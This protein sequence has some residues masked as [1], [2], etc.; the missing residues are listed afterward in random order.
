MV[1]EIKSP[2]NVY[3]VNSEKIF[4][5]DMQSTSNGNDSDKYKDNK[6]FENNLKAIASSAENFSDSGSVRAEDRAL[7]CKYFLGI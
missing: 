1:V 2:K 4:K 6:Q 7:K 3:V 5:N